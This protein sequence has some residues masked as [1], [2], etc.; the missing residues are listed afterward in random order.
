MPKL[1][2]LLCTKLTMLDN[3]YDTLGK[4]MLKQALRNG[5][6]GGLTHADFL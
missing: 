3:E 5:M 4:I 2:N 6:P 1:C